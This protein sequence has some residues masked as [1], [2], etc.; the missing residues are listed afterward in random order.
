MNGGKRKVAILCGGRSG[1]HEISLRS[2]RSI[3]DAI[4]QERFEVQLIGIDKDGHWHRIDAAELRQLTEQG[5]LQLAGG[6][7]EVALAPVPNQGRSIEPDRSAPPLGAE[8][9]FPVLHGTFG[10]D[11]CIQGLLELADLPYVGAG[12]LGSAV[13]MDKDVQ[14]RLL[15]AAGL[16][17]VPF[18]TTS[19]ARLAADA[20]GERQRIGE[21]G[22]P[23]FVK[24]ANLGSSVGISKVDAWAELD[25]AID[26]AAGYDTKL[27]IERGID[28]RE[29]ECAVLGND[30]PEAS[31]AGEVCPQADFY[32]YEAKYVDDK[33]AKLLIPAPI[34]A[35]EM[36]WV[37]AL[38]VQVFRELELA[39]M[40]RVDFFLERGTGQWYVNEV[41][42]LPGFTNIS[43]YPKLWE[44]SGLPYGELITRLIDLAVERHQQRS[45]L[46]RSFAPVGS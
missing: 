23:L 1:E 41:N 45:R 2:A 35:A 17:V 5:L 39:G 33:G 29:I 16:P 25:S 19:R 43:M 4:D 20:E 11:G 10:E 46:R 28:A 7:S 38:A 18:V 8:V 31:I 27:V 6:S 13:G 32:S 44:A 14:K 40:A 24:P 36:A 42:T 21:L 3:V 15:R 34:S 26:T 37:R 22:L 30:E 12:V 9:V